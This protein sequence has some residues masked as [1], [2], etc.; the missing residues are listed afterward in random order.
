[1]NNSPH[2]KNNNQL[3]KGK[4]QVLYQLDSDTKNLTRN[5]KKN[6]IIKRKAP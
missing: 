3:N 2:E 4:R 5:L 6:K 1:M